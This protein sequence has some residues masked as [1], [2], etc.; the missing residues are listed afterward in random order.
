MAVGMW[1]RTGGMVWVIGTLFYIVTRSEE[2][3]TKRAVGWEEAEEERLKK[4]FWNETS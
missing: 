3:E 4:W 2:E 1:W